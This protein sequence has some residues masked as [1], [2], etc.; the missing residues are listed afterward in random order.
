MEHSKPALQLETD[1]E[2]RR[3][4]VELGKTLPAAKELCPP[5][6]LPT[7]MA[8]NGAG[9]YLPGPLTSP[10]PVKKKPEGAFP[11]QRIGNGLR[12]PLVCWMGPYIIKMNSE[13][14]NSS[15]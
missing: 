6:S 7:F 4:A 11:F 14:E 12:K 9:E 10:N 13:M 8:D 2:G 15:Q 1:N 5:A 3:Q